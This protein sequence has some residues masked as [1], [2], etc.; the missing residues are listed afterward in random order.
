MFWIGAA[1]GAFVCLVAICVGIGCIGWSVARERSADAK[2]TDKYRVEKEKLYEFWYEC[3]AIAGRN[4]ETFN[5]I[6]NAL[7]AIER[8]R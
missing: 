5:R 1:A 7:D 4:A 2:D 6:A 8:N 3:N